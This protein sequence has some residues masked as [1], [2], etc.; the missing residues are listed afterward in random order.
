MLKRISDGL[1]EQKSWI[2]LEVASKLTSDIV[3]ET[4]A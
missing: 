1:L 2:D 3:T 4:L